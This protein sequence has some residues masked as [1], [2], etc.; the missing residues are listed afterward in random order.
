MNTV[1]PSNYWTKD[2]D[3]SKTS[4][5]PRRKSDGAA[6]GRR[7]FWA[8]SGSIISWKRLLLASFFDRFM[9]M[10]AVQNAGREIRRTSG[11]GCPKRG[12]PNEVDHSERATGIRRRPRCLQRCAPSTC[13]RKLGSL[14][15]AHSGPGFHPVLRPSEGN[16]ALGGGPPRPRKP[17]ES[18]A[19][20]NARASASG[21][22]RSATP[23]AHLR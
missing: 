12:S 7:R 5:S 22:D 16:R 1:S 11:R 13:G 9:V 10:S 18:A 17:S 19:G 23:P 4:T 6:T 2:S 20:G 8:P 3:P 14:E 21:Q 15:N